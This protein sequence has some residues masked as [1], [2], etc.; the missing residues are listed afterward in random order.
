MDK[1]ITKIIITVL[2]VYIVLLAGGAC[3]LMQGGK[4]MMNSME[5]S[6]Q[7]EQYKG[8]GDFDDNGNGSLLH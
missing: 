4:M 3:L 6:K 5:K 1:S 2:I 8:N 7:I